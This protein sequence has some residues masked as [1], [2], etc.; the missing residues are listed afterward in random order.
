MT[1]IEC[2]T[3]SH[4]DNIA[5]CLGLQ[6]D[7]LIF[8]GN[9]KEMEEP[10]KRYR[11]LLQRRNMP[12]RVS[13]C[14]VA[15]VD[16]N[17]LCQGLTKLV[18]DAGDCIID[19]T[20][21]APD[22]IMAVGAV[23]A[24]LPGDVR[25]RVQIKKYDHCAGVVRDCITGVESN[26]C[27][28]ATISVEEMIELHGGGFRA[29][30]YQPPKSCDSRDIRRIWE[31]VCEDPKQWNHEM[32]LLSEAE[33]RSVSKTQVFLPLFYLRSSISGFGKKEEEIREI[34]DK[35]RDSGIIREERRS[36]AW[37][38]SYPDELMRYC[39]QKAGNV[40]EVKTLLES[41]AVLDRGEPF[42]RDCQMSVTIDWDGKEEKGR[43]RTPDTC[44]EVDVV[45]MHG[46][47]PVFVSCKN[48]NVDE[49]ELYKL[50]TVAHWFGG[51]YAKKMLV[52]TD[53]NWA[54]NRALIYRA[55]DMGI[56]I[57]TDGADR[58]SSQ[59]AEAFRS[60]VEQG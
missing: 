54:E 53:L 27:E 46:L 55:Q 49:N 57:V 36:D 19:L 58:S 4:I 9:G 17:R 59:W 7:R 37:S 48:G 1:L 2:F 23:Y 47:T 18:C 39:T 21:G 35:L 12:T 38:Y 29:G 40:L 44:N 6:P 8:F 60:A 42:F 43:G 56:R 22:V 13:A 11:Q 30:A 26:K 33:S 16:F 15:E 25:R 5:A 24:Q 32:A 20:G 28:Q 45:L 31:M 14:D 41:R 50:H 34:L 51:P 52:A 10:L 3:D